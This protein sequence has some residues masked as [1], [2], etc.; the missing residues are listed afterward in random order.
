MCTFESDH[1]VLVCDLAIAQVRE[2]V[3]A[4]FCAILNE[5][6]ARSTLSPVCPS[7]ITITGQYAWRS[8]TKTGPFAPS[9]VRPGYTT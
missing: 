1:R 3:D 5:A 2:A 6:S 9:T 7:P 8:R 4:A